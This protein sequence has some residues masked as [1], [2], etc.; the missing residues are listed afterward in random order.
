[1]KVDVSL[2][3]IFLGVAGCSIA[4]C[5]YKFC[6]AKKDEKTAS[7]KSKGINTI[8]QKQSI[9]AINDEKVHGPST[10]GNEKKV[11]S[12]KEPSLDGNNQ[13]FKPLEANNVNNFEEN[14]VT[15]LRSS[16]VPDTNSI[17]SSKNFVDDKDQEINLSTPKEQQCFLQTDTSEINPGN[18]KYAG[19]SKNNVEDGAEPISNIKNDVLSSNGKLYAENSVTVNKQLCSKIETTTPSD[20]KEKVSVKSS[21]KDLIDPILN[22]TEEIPDSMTSVVVENKVKSEALTI[23]NTIEERSEISLEN[24]NTSQL[25]DKNASIVNNKEQIVVTDDNLA[26]TSTL[27][28]NKKEDSSMNSDAFDNEN[29]NKESNLN[30]QNPKITLKKSETVKVECKKTFSIDKIAF[31]SLLDIVENQKNEL[32][33]AKMNILK[34]KTKSA[35]NLTNSKNK[36]LQQINIVSDE[37]LIK[38]LFSAERTIW[39]DISSLTKYKHLYSLHLQKILEFYRMLIDTLKKVVFLKSK[40]E[41]SLQIT[42]DEA[43][44]LITSFNKIIKCIQQIHNFNNN[45]SYYLKSSIKN[46]FKEILKFFRS[47]NC[48]IGFSSN[49]SKCVCIKL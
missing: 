36:R 8:D 43:D 11:V 16:E 27:L 24:Q 34:N 45:Q 9:S 48:G 37:K 6:F 22:V 26:T 30:K 7:L 35:K 15:N 18:A 28:C 12:S 39:T 19:S 5:A 17:D 1:M 21:I 41:K 13:K 31:Q 10:L 29:Q 3:N 23:Y 44:D 42:Q 47:N 46:V 33:S 32:A 38:D 2:G 49:F 4:V 25:L 40:Q 20:V 14:E